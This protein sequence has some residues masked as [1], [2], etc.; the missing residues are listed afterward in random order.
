MVQSIYQK[1][2]SEYISCMLERQDQIM[3][4]TAQHVYLMF[5]AV[6]FAILVAVPLG[7]FIT[8][9]GIGQHPQNGDEKGPRGSV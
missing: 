9:H 4:L 8:R 2:N 6:V 3:E 1:N 5:I 7:I